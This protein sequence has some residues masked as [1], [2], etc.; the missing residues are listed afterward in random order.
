MGWTKNLLYGAHALDTGS[1]TL[2]GKPAHENISRIGCYLTGYGCPQDRR[3]QNN[4]PYEGSPQNPVAT[5]GVTRA[6][7]NRV[8]SKPTAHSN[9]KT[10]KKKSSKGVA[11]VAP[12]KYKRKK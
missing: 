5:R 8:F 6:L 3:P 1:R 10:S 7:P 4:Y 9:K 12:K 11:K 2:T